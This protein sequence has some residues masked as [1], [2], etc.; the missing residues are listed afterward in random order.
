MDINQKDRAALNAKLCPDCGQPI[1]NYFFET[2]R[3]WCRACDVWFESD[4]SG[5]VIRNLDATDQYNEDWVKMVRE[6]GYFA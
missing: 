1:K 2:N 6:D 4:S 5:W 3:P